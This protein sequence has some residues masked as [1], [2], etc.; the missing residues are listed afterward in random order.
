MI[1]LHYLHLIYMDIYST[2]KIANNL[3][4]IEVKSGEYYACLKRTSNQ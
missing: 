4:M 1:S 2:S 3:R